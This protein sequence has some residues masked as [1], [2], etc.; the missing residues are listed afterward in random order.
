M[1]TSKES[2]KKFYMILEEVPLLQLLFS[3]TLIHIRISKK[4]LSLS[5]EC[6]L[7]C[8]STVET[9]PQSILETLFQLQTF[10]MNSAI[11]QTVPGKAKQA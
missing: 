5:R 1:V 3:G 6:T 10:L 7:E 8:T 11:V 9:K 4:T 2:S